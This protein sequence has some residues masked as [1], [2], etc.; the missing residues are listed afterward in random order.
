[1]TESQVESITTAAVAVTEGE[2]ALH[3]ACG[4]WHGDRVSEGERDSGSQ[5][6]GTSLASFGAQVNHNNIK[7]D[8]QPVSGCSD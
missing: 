7:F 4:M 6:Q 5:S 8:F 1:M 2:R 3:G